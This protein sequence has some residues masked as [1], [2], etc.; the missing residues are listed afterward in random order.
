M[1]RSPLALS[2]SFALLGL[3]ACQ[4]PAPTVGGRVE[5]ATLGLAFAS[6]PPG[7]SV[8]TNEGATLELRGGTERGVGTLMVSVGEPE[9]SI[10]LVETVQ[11][12]RGSF[13]A[14]QGG[15]YFGFREIVTP[16][17]TAYTT[18]G[19]F[20]AGDGQ[21]TEEIRL[22]TIHPRGDR[23]MNWVYRYVAGGDTQQ[24]MEQLLALL[25]EVEAFPPPAASAP[26]APSSN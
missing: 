4:P 12:Q 3:A 23:R 17:A 15:Q 6:L 9:S 25:G 16:W 21:E 1:S 13:E 2:L 7:F 18:R 19:R 10:N 22:F 11:A 24:R 5:S 20:T 14:M 8:G 26:S